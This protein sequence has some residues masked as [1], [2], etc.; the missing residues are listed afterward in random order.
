MV[1]RVGASNAGRAAG[2]AERRAGKSDRHTC[3]QLPPALHMASWENTLL[4]LLP[5]VQAGVAVLY[6]GRVPFSDVRDRGWARLRGTRIGRSVRYRADVLRNTPPRFKH[7]QARMLNLAF[8]YVAHGQVAGHYLEFGVWDGGTFVRAWRASQRNHLSE[9]RFFAFDSFSGLP[10]L[11]AVDQG[12][13]FSEGEL[14][15]SR[16]VFDEELGRAGVDPSRVTVVE[17]F[18]DTTLDRA[19]QPAMGLD[20][21]AIVWIDCDL[22]VSTVPVLDYVSDLLV[23]GSVLVFDDWYC[24]HARPDR[25]EQRACAEWLDRT[26]D[27][28]LVPYRD[29]HWAGRSF[30]VNR[31]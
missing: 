2:A 27:V 10:Q 20:R 7:E 30:I 14:A 8:D 26:P 29:F 9:M 19:A 31:S 11:S 16:D 4:M 22:Y 1:P 25:G 13:E 3:P 21:A 15:V 12:G 6:A 18:F 23:D 5:P 28:A 24:Y 17:G